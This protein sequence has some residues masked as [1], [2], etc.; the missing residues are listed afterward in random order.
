MRGS[1]DK[2][3]AELRQREAAAMEQREASFTSDNAVR[4]MTS[5]LT[6]LQSAIEA[7][8]RDRESDR[9]RE[10]GTLSQP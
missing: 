4:A 7:I 1:I 2:L 9:R 6:A 5:R 10:L 3:N 8:V